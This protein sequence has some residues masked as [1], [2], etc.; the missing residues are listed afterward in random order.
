MK[1]LSLALILLFIPCIFLFSSC[2]KG[3]KI[4]QYKIDCTLIDNVLEG[5]EEVDFYNDSENAFSVLKFNLHAN[6]FREDAKY[7]PIAS[8]YETKAYYDGK[9][10]GNL[11]IKKVYSDKEDLEYIVTGEDQ[12]VLDV[13]LKE[14]VFPEERVKIY[15]EYTLNVAKVIARTG[16]TKNTVN[17][18]N[19]YPILCAIENG[20]FYECLYYSNGDPYFSDCADYTVNFTCDEKYVVA[21]SGENVQNK[22]IN[23]KQQN[24]YK[25]DNARSFAIVL[26]EH[27]KTLS[28]TVNGVNVIYYYYTEENAEEFLSTAVKSVEYFENV[29][30][31]YGYNTY[32][33]V[34][35]QFMQGGMEFPALVMISD[36]LEREA[37][38]EVIVHETAHQWWQT[39]VGNNEIEY[40][41]L[42][43]GLAEYSVILFYENHS[44]YG[45]D[46]KTLV[47]SAE[48]TY[49]IF[50]SVY[51]KLFGNVNTTML[52]SLKDFNAEYEYVNI[53]YV[54][55]CIMYDNL[56]NAI[57]EEEFFNSLRNYY[58]KYKFKNATPDCLVSEFEKQVRDAK[59]YFY[60]FFEGKAIL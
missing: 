10:Y 21:S 26:S 54:K 34:E 27:F 39:G 52:R 49:K 11:E 13:H 22:K 12:N 40:G 47:T 24:V 51:D 8:S 2:E 4:S 15:I 7:K 50:C 35:T 58:E 25:I 23:G 29:F 59:G 32:S 6:A 20:S 3:K 44:E 33:V 57:G 38:N 36:E 16:I 55:P 41:F 17:L 46:R 28:K 43:E 56:R 30:G 14:E 60:S 31:K 42:D 5:V 45:L 18:A 9:S 53:A 48:K 19:F 37:Y 1:K